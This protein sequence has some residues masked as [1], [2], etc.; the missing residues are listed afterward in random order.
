MHPRKLSPTSSL[1]LLWAE[2]QVYASDPSKRFLDGIRLD[3]GRALLSKCNQIWPHYGEVIKNRKHC[4]LDLARR[5]ITGD[6]IGQV[7]ILGAG[8]DPLSLELCSYSKEIRVFEIDYDGMDTKAALIQSAAPA[9]GDSVSCITADISRPGTVIRRLVEH[10]WEDG[11]PS[12]AII[13]GVS[14]YLSA[15]DLWGL[16]GRFGTEDHANAVILEYLLPSCMVAKNRAAIPDRVF[17]AILDHFGLEGVTRYSAARIRELLRS[18]G[19]VLRDHYDMG[20]MERSRTSQ[21]RHFGAR[22]SGWI[23]VCRFSI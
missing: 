2:G 18:A 19:G 7:I 21:N 1:V 22:G 9:L 10:G 14:Y 16:I 15:E 12:L 11:R 4:V 23:E 17:Q 20:G 13:E 5:S 6:G 8:A 3:S